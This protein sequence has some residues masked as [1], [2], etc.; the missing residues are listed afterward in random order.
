MCD[1]TLQMGCGF[2][3]AGPTSCGISNFRLIFLKEITSFNLVFSQV[4]QVSSET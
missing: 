3:L 4:N 1:V 2:I